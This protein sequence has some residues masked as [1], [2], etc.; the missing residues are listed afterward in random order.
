MKK[1]FLLSFILLTVSATVSAQD[2]YAPILQEI[3]VNSRQ[4]SLSDREYRSAMAENATGLTLADPEAEVGY[5]LGDGH[6]RT[7]FSVKQGFD[8]PTVYNR[9]RRLARLKDTSAANL[10]DAR[11]TEV[12][13][14]AKELLIELTYW[15]ALRLQAQKQHDYVSRLNEIYSQL[16]QTGQV[17]QIDCNKAALNYV[18]SQNELA[19]IDVSRSD[20]LDRLASLNGGKAITF[21]ATEFIPELLPA[22]FDRW[23]ETAE[24]A[25]PALRY[26]RTEVEVSDGNISVVKAETLPKWS[27]GV[28]GEYV[29]GSNFTGV[30]VGV[31]IPL[32]ENRGK[33]HRART[34]RAVAEER[35]ADARQDY[36]LT[37]RSL[38]NQAAAYGRMEESY[39]RSLSESS[40]DALLYKA[41]Q[42]GQLS[43]IDYVTEMQYQFTL[44]EKLLAARRDR[45]LAIARLSAFSL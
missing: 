33:V 38:F 42:A 1:I 26:L 13:L 19:R 4:I 11:R 27:V 17:T 14:Q 39:G 16:I 37:L 28:Q 40:N 24:A 45:A 3:A 20:I 12:L 41:L 35:L 9:R 32:W 7:D 2:P 8:F 15:N 25:N 18:N 30:T 44:Q 29:Y 31:S 21:E 5:L 43:L 23:F 22:D 10:N 34:Q 6:N 36:Y